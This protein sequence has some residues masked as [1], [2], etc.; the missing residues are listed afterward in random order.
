MYTVKDL[1]EKLSKMDP[2]AWVVTGSR[3]FHPVTEVYESTVG[4]HTKHRFDMNE[5]RLGEKV[6][7]LYA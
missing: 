2:D 1:I 6:V 3:E 7:K 4:A 5:F